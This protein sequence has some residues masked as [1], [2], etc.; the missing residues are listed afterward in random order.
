MTKP[1]T[2]ESLLNKIQ[3]LLTLAGREDTPPH[4]AKLAQERAEV[5]M[6]KYRID[7]AMLAF[8]DIGKQR[9]IIV[10]DLQR[11]REDY[12][13]YLNS[14]MV[15]VYRHYE[16]PTSSAWN[17]I[18]AVGYEDDLRMASVVWSGV[19]MDFV[20]K[21][22]PVWS[23]S[24]SFDQNVYLLKE[25]GKS[26]MDIVLAAP[27]SAQLNR[28][29]GGRLRA[30]YQRWAKAID[31]DITPHSRNPKKW[32]AAFV[33][34]YQTRLSQRLFE[35][36]MMREDE[37]KSAQDS[38]SRVSLALQTD[39]ERVLAEFYRLFPD[40]DP[41]VQKKRNQEFMEREAARRAALTQEER[42]A[43]DKYYKRMDRKMRNRPVRYHDAAGW[44][45]GTKAADSIDL[46][47]TKV[48]GSGSKG[49]IG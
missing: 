11:H 42:D 48:K 47:A 49:A 25:S 15:N 20:S 43:E 23:D 30:S 18:A 13:A 7:M 27:E 8:N 26:W 35:L 10:H 17:R 36:K 31:A 5:M 1:D 6:Q 22:M 44:S 34:A 40:Y 38:D 12:A 21:M 16:C 28:N 24:R 19:H 2:N 3:N 39:S 37:N 4:E 14:M 41:A 46:G 45:A 33:D 9:E 29:S 32:R